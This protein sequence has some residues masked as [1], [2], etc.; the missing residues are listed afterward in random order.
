M[1]KWLLSIKIQVVKA[2]L[3]VVAG[4]INRKDCKYASNKMSEL[5]SS[6]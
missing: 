2:S 6:I 3:L 5:R 1:V 4:V